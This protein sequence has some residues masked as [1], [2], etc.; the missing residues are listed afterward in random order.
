MTSTPSVPEGLPAPLSQASK[1]IGEG[2]LG[3]AE[4]VLRVFVHDHPEDVN[5]IRLLGEV[6]LA[7]GA[8]RDAENLLSRAVELAPDYNAAR[9][10]YANALYRRHRY[11]ESLK[12]LGRLLA[13]E[14]DNPAWRTLQA[15]N[16]VDLN[17]H[18]KALPVLE[19]IIENHPEYRQAWLSYGHAQRA[20]G[21]TELAI[22]AY[23]Q[24]IELSSGVGEAYWSL[25]NLKTYRFSAAQIEAMEALLSSDNC[26]F[27]DYYHALF[28]LGK[29]REDAGEHK[30][31]M[32]A[33]LKG[34]QVR[35][36]QVPWDID[37][38]ERDSRQIMDFF[39]PVFFADREGWG[40]ADTSPI[41]VVG[42][43]RAGSTLVEQ[44]LASHSQ[45]EGTAELAD[46]IAIARDLSGKR[47]QRDASLYPGSLAELEAADVQMLGERYIQGTQKQ[48]LTDSPFFVDKMP[49]NFSHVGLIHL[50]LPHAKIIDARRHPLDCCF[51]AFKQL[52]AA[53]Q[54]FSYGLQRIGH[55]YRWYCETMA[56]WDE[57]LPGRVHR[58]HHERLLDDFEGEV[59]RL[60][61]YCDLPFE[62]QC[63]SFHETRRRVRTASSEQV[64]QPINRDGMGRWEPYAEWLG[65]LREA[66]GPALKAYPGD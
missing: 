32:A 22:E 65:P 10:A 18:H 53:G 30:K 15:A 4:G 16:L 25:A 28:A 60:L 58:V 54:G 6:G 46:I 23:E 29:A 37:G 56:H 13:Q 26:D 7:L 39:D 14:P 62:E 64:R 19:G 1:L 61:G 59:R 11:E 2:A 48:R 49:N 47:R 9:F 51:S 24:C 41:F 66:L 27:R 17:E 34:N 21:E 57:V 45:V 52:F 38:F 33:Y 43:P 5:G 44:I 63:L 42:L 40:A 12:E 35:G 55:Y 50:I 36:R 8:L 3:K 31:A 20:L